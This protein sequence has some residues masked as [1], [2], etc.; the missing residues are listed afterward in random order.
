[1]AVGDIDNDGRVDA[2]VTTSDGPADLLH[3]ETVTGNHWLTLVLVGH[4]SNRH[5]FCVLI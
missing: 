5:G 4:R 3:N 2:V 1:M